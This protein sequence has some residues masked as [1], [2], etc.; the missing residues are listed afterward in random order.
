MRSPPKYGIS[1][2]E[3]DRDNNVPAIRRDV[4]KLLARAMPDAL[5][6]KNSIDNNGIPD[7]V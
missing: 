5:T 3:K 6:P 7:G 1:G 4:A 2:V